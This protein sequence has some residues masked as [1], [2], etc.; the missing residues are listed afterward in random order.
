MV[1]NRN[2]KFDRQCTS[3][4]VCGWFKS[5]VFTDRN[6]FPLESAAQNRKLMF[7]GPLDP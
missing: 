1:P 5:Y 2:R 4:Q 3:I 7:Q 6:F